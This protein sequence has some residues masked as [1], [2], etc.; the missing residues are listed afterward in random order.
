MPA[1]LTETQQLHCVSRGT[2]LNMYM[3]APNY[4]PQCA[5]IFAS[6]T[7]K[8]CVYTKVH[9]H[10]RP[11]FIY[12]NQETNEVLAV[13]SLYLRY[14]CKVCRHFTVNKEL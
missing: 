13:V 6:V 8:N 12:I 7:L 2:C 5:T 14:H 3:Q 11:H 10:V 9:M 4:L 1:S